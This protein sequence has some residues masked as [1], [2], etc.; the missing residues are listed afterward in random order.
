M[1]RNLAILLFF[2][3]A[4]AIGAEVPWKEAEAPVR[5]RASADPRTRLRMYLP[6]PQGLDPSLN[7]VSAFTDKEESMTAVPVFRE[8]RLIGVAVDATK[9]EHIAPQRATNLPA[10][11]F[12]VYLKAGAA[13]ETTPLPAPVLV[14][15]RSATLTARPFSSDEILRYLAQLPA[16]EKMEWAPCTA[17]GGLPDIKNWLTPPK[18]RFTVAILQWEAKLN[19]EQD[20]QWAF[21]SEETNVT[22]L[23]L[24]DGTPAASWR[25]A[26]RPR[27]ESGGFAAPV[28]LSAGLHTLQFI[29]V[30]R[31][32][33]PIPQC[34]MRPAGD[35]GPGQ[36]P[37][38]L[39]PSRV[40][41][42]LTATFRDS[43]D[44]PIVLS[45][46]AI[47]PIQIRETNAT[48]ACIRV[49][50]DTSETHPTTFRAPDGTPLAAANG[51]ILCPPGFLPAIEVHQG[52]TI[53]SLPADL[54]WQEPILVRARAS[55]SGLPMVLPPDAPLS[56]ICS[57]Q[58]PERL[59]P[60]IRE[61]CICR[62]DELD[63]EGATVASQSLPTTR[64][65]EIPFALSP[66][67][68]TQRLRIHIQFSE[69]DILPPMDIRLIRP[70]QANLPL[71]LRSK[72][73]VDAEGLPVVF[74]CN[75]LNINDLQKN[76]PVLARPANGDALRLAVLDD[77]ITPFHS[78]S[79]DAS[80]KALLEQE[81]AAPL[82]V[83]CHPA[84][85]TLETPLEAEA[86]MGLSALLAAQPDAALL[87]VGLRPFQR[88]MSPEQWTPVLVF[89]LQSC[90]TAGIAP[91][92]VTLPKV[93]GYPAENA[94]RAA[95]LT[96]ELAVA[97]GLP[98]IDL[99]SQQMIQGEAPTEWFKLPSGDDSR[100]LR[101]RAMNNSARTW[102]AATCA[103]ALDTFLKP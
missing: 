4:M 40:P 64:T 27:P 70:E 12:S 72:Q 8:G 75:K 5:L 37:T 68:K 102:W 82:E 88:G 25:E 55:L 18:K 97:V 100:P 94:Y 58:W 49:P 51:R 73:L 54:Y 65:G 91:V 23:L 6:V 99:Y 32:E 95:R 79:A 24:V 87:C 48:I 9:A 74:I 43:P 1:L 78:V 45:R 76:R 66:S 13:A 69:K 10:T 14:A 53:L 103:H 57:I 15:K 77:V 16:K 98:V 50:Q 39:L 92:L 21:G 71:F 7:T 30:L 85:S 22:W 33:E 96:K 61:A 3:A 90:H 46:M 81:T 44:K 83:S 17:I 47:H 60:L 38:P 80:L 63:G 62:L 26:T 41:F 11:S 34:L 35:E 52:D 29:T 28:A 59:S 19:L 84:A 31:P 2:V 93:P 42:S 67:E 20:G 101:S 86:L 56:A 36:P 89:L